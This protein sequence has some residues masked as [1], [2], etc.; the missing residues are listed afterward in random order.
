VCGV[1]GLLKYATVTLV[2]EPYDDEC[3]R[4]WHARHEERAPK[5]K[6]CE[7]DAVLKACGCTWSD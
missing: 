7:C 1:T 5:G 3:L 2:H 6:A 4:F